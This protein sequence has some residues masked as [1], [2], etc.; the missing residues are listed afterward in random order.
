M[1]GQLIGKYRLVRLLG[2]G[3]MGVVWEAERDD[4]GGRVALKILRTEYAQQAEF[5]AR[6][7]N[8]AHATNAID[9]PAMVKVFDHGQTP[10]GAAFLA[11]EF[12][13]G[14]SLASHLEK[15][16]RMPTLTVMRL[17]RQVASAIAAAHA[18]T[19]IHRDLKPE[20]IMLV[21][22]DDSLGGERVKILD[23]GIAK[24]VNQSKQT[25]QTQGNIVMGTPPYMSPEQCA[26]GKGIT[27]KSDVYALGIILYQMLAGRTPFVSDEPGRYIGMHLF[28]EPPPLASLAP[29]TPGPLVELVHAMLAK[30]AKE[31]PP[32]SEVAA[33]L[34]RL[35][36]I[37]PS[38]LSH[39]SLLRAP[40]DAGEGPIDF[41]GIV[42]TSAEVPFV[43]GPTVLSDDPPALPPSLPPRL[44]SGPRPLVAPVAPVVSA[45]SASL[46]ERSQPLPGQPRRTVAI[47]AAGV[48]LAALLA[49][50]LLR[51]SNP[52][53]RP[54]PTVPPTE[55]TATAA[56]RAVAEGRSPTAAL[57]PP[58]AAEASPQDRGPSDGEQRPREDTEGK[59]NDD[60]APSRSKPGPAPRRPSFTQED[61]D[62]LL[63]QARN[64]ASDGNQIAAMND[65]YQ[66][67]QRGNAHNAWA[68]SAVYACNCKNLRV[69]NEAIRHLDGKSG[70]RFWYTYAVNHCR[71]TGY[72]LTP[73]HRLR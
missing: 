38:P 70:D 6:F 25:V 4:L 43:E 69:A 61:S 23:F 8:E 66:A 35:G 52:D 3:G 56:N 45:A 24:I 29:E 31:R 27:E 67:A 7:F 15:T 73:D 21:P 32:M 55:E 1:Q 28:K 60:R 65:A 26:G 68:M 59:N 5:S 16:P 11:M 51:R 2:E 34:Q 14:E 13:A 17:G 36:Q 53:H 37:P 33:T 47:V 22:D 46:P 20:N 54:R 12:V 18:K 9:H 62:R 41:T 71:K 63:I 44:A 48:G 72:Q 50:L 40:S 42:L 64:R 10:D 19:I 57:A 39:P 49:L 58:G 30:E